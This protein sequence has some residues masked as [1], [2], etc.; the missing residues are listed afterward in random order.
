MADEFKIDFTVSA[1]PVEKQQ[2]A[3]GTDYC[4]TAHSAIDKVIG[5]AISKSFGATSTKV[6]RDTATISTTPITLGNACTGI[7][8]NIN[9][10][11]IVCTAVIGDGE[12]TVRLGTQTG[13]T[14][15]FAEVG[16][17]ILITE[18]R[19]SQSTYADSNI[20][21]TRISGGGSIN[22]EVIVGLS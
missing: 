10:I 18:L 22:I 20:I 5:G 1:T 3:N 2:L 11:L 8:G 16:D 13:G 7:S 9:S 17:M 6:V 19:D 14:G 4:Y 15:S 12:W 21:F